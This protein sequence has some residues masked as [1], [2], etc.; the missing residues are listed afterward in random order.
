MQKSADRHIGI[1][2]ATPM[3]LTNCRLLEVPRRVASARRETTIPLMYHLGLVIT[4]SERCLQE[5]I[6][7]R[8]N[9]SDELTGGRL[10]AKLSRYH[11]SETPSHF[12]QRDL[13]YSC[14]RHSTLARVERKAIFRIYDFPSGMRGKTRTTHSPSRIYCHMQRLLPYSQD[15][16]LLRNFCDL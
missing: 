4:Q 5:N 7:S 11:R 1:H 14:C 15:D 8:A 2:I 10:E 12:N 9:R 13:N 16:T 3:D 6:S